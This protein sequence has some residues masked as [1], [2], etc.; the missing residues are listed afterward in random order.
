MNDSEHG[1]KETNE[2]ADR[3]GRSRPTGRAKTL[4][5]NWRASPLSFPEKLALAARNNLVKI[6]R[7]RDCCGHHG[8]PGC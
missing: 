2:G 7:R 1:K 3:Q 5:S 4:L 6:R 8:E